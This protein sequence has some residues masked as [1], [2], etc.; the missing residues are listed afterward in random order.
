MKL[1]V[2]IETKF[3]KDIQNNSTVKNNT[4]LKNITELRKTTLDKK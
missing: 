3:K 1:C 2:Q 4:K